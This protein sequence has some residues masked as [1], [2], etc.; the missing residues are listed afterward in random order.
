MEWQ[1]VLCQINATRG[2]VQ[3]LQNALAEKGYS[4]GPI[5]GILGGAT[6]KAVNEYASSLGIPQGANYVPLDVLKRLGLKI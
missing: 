3:A 4:V 5:D 1:Q 2:N 6:I